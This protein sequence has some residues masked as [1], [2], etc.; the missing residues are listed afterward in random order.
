MKLMT[1]FLNQI[2]LVFPE[3]FCF[4]YTIFTFSFD[5]RG[6]NYKGYHMY[7]EGHRVTDKPSVCFLKYAKPARC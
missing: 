1:V 5:N 7:V 6:A 3:D 2:F 4:D